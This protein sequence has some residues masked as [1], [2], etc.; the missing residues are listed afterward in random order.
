[1]WNYSLKVATFSLKGDIQLQD[2]FLCSSTCDCDLVNS[3]NWFIIM[4][5]DF[6]VINRE[7]SVSYPHIPSRLYSSYLKVWDE[8]VQIDESS[9][10]FNEKWNK[11]RQPQPFYNHIIIPDLTMRPSVYYHIL[12]ANIYNLFLWFWMRVSDVL[13]CDLASW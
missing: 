3:L 12:E 13:E 11:V 9:A 2:F 10:G 1:M 6:Y 5:H 7:K 8:L 4:I